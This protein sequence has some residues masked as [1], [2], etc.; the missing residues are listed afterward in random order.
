MNSQIILQND[1]ED[2]VVDYLSSNNAI[3]EEEKE[4]SNQ[5]FYSTSTQLDIEI[6]KKLSNVK[7]E[8][9]KQNLKKK[10]DICSHENDYKTKLNEIMSKYKN[11]GS[12]NEKIDKFI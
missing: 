2:K 12:E 3:K 10:M 1:D 8:S 5:V 7:N 9:Q 4:Q 11:A 6:L